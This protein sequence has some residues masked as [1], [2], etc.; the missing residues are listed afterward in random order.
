MLA[1]AVAVRRFIL[2]AVAV[3]VAAVLDN[4]QQTV[5]LVRQTLVAAAVVAVAMRETQLVAQAVRAL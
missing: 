2:L 4:E 3:Q 5:R 1:V